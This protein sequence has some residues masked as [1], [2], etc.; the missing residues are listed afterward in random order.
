[1]PTFICS[2]VGTCK[3]T[4]SQVSSLQVLPLILV[5][6]GA[7]RK[8][9][10]GGQKGMY[11][12]GNKDHQRGLIQWTQITTNTISRRQTKTWLDMNYLF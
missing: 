7:Y 5:T 12:R 4:C 1:M 2:A 10:E 11:F 6:E 8:Y 9:T 3:T